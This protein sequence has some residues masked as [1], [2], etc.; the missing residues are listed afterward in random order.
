MQPLQRINTWKSC[1]KGI[2]Y[3]INNWENGYSPDCWAYYIYIYPDHVSK[4]VFSK[5]WKKTSRS[6]S[7]CPALEDLAW[8]GGCTYLERTITNGNK[9]IKAGCDY[10]HAFDRG[11][12]YTPALIQEDIIK[13]IDQ[14]IEYV[15]E[16]NPSDKILT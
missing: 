8:H 12:T 1:Y 2:N 9:M 10:Q 13:T 4:H 11:C 15:N 14:Y 6:L 7:Q 5:L 3:S 16:H